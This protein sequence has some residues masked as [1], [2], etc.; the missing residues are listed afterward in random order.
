M[1]MQT[2]KCLQSCYLHY[3]VCLSSSSSSSPPPSKVETKLISTHW[4]IRIECF[5]WLLSSGSTLSI[6][7]DSNIYTPKKNNFQTTKGVTAYSSR[8]LNLIL[9]CFSSPLGPHTLCS[10]LQN[11]VPTLS[12]HFTLIGFTYSQFPYLHLFIIILI[13][14]RIVQLMEGLQ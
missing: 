11:T 13:R 2:R 3:E 4:Q 12:P 14:I 6:G 1:R 5:F 10:H 7:K 8:F 9:L